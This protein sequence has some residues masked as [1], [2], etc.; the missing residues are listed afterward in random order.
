[1]SIQMLREQRGKIAATL[2]D[3]VNKADWSAADDQPAYDAM[4]TEIDQIDDRIRRIQDA[5]ARLVEEVRIDALA[6]SA[7]RIGRDRADRGLSVFAKWIKGGDKALSAEDWAHVRNA[8]STTTGSEGGFTVDSEV[9]GSVL[10]AMKAFGGMRAV[11]TVIATSGVGAMSFPTSDGTAEE[12]ELV[13]EN[14][15]ATDADV[16]FGTIALPVYKFSSK[17]VTVPF[18]LLQ[19]STVDVEAL[20]RA[21]LATR[22]GRLTNRLFTTG[23]GTGEPHGVV[24]AAPVGVTAATGTSQV[25]A[26]TYDSLVALQHSVDPSYRAL[27]AA[28]WM[29]N[30]ATL[31]KL[32][33]VKDLSGRPIF[34]PGYETANPGGAFDRLLGAPV[35]I[36]Q[37]MP[38]MAAN[39]RSIAFGDFSHYYIRDVMAVELFRFTDSAFTRKGQVGF[40]AWMR[41]GGNLIDIGG[42][43]KVFVNAAS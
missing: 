14:Q 29:F 1:M 31:M 34:V 30:D 41:S 8:M 18:E 7:A 38:D 26:V 2:Q 36:N 5:H 4:M 43:V 20:V 6:D 40:L 19:D 33:L 9:A 23:T 10:E 11:S 13:A 35:T 32:R 12:G 28:R 24:T 42:A 27:G 16:S 17:V 39:A 22:L 25:T 37:N 21:R 15:S 3:L